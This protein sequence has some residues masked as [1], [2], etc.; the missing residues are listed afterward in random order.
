MRTSELRTWV[1]ISKGAMLHNARMF[2]KILPKHIG[3][4]AVVKS[5]AY[6]HG[7]IEAAKL[8][9][10][11]IDFFAVVFIEEALELRRHGIRKPILV[12]STV[13]FDKKKLARAIRDDISFSVYD[14][15]SYWRINNAAKRSRKPAIVHI[16]VDTGM[17]R[18]GFSNDG[19]EQAIS[20]VCGGNLTIQGLYSHLSSADS[21]IP[22]TKKQCDRFTE[23]VAAAED[24]HC[25]IPYQHILNTPGAMLGID[26]GNLAR[27]GLGLFG[28][29]PS[30]LSEREAKKLFR[31]FKLK[32]ALSWKTRV[33]QVRTVDANT[34]VGYGRTY[35]TREKTTLATIPI[36]FADGY[37][38]SLSNNGEVLIKGKRCPIRGNVCMSNIMVDV[39]S[40]SNTKPG[41]EVV[42]I[43][44]SGKQVISVND[45]AARRNT[46]LS[47]VVTAIPESI[48]R[49]YR[50]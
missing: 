10:K 49:I 6:G 16:N 32:P 42:L 9:E 23:A 25:D 30:D 5:N 7:M 35:R 46:N 2:R 41:D 20:R 48:P 15:E 50:G 31:S 26:A 8:L 17:S 24:A 47:E 18:L 33:I 34:S 14:D 27:I 45:I 36:G 13:T 21:D 19:H 37:S 28:L 39:S 40:V 22:F 29:S 4:M 1:D 12:F 11:K 3:I 38:R 44:T 43:G